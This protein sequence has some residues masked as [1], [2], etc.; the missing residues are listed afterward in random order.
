[1]E[2]FPIYR[3]LL[4]A[5]DLEGAGRQAD[6]QLLLGCGQVELGT[7]QL[8][9]GERLGT[10]LVGALQEVLVV[11]GAEIPG[12]IL[13]LQCLHSRVG[14]LC[15]NMSAEKAVGECYIWFGCI[16]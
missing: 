2:Y 11:R 4:L 5:L 12:K 14:C 8:G 15:T 13:F 9:D 7:G 3:P 1:M 16:L 10:F 6:F